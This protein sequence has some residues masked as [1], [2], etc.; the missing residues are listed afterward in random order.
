MFLAALNTLFIK[1]AIIACTF[2]LWLPFLK[3]LYV[4]LND[5]L[6]AE[7]GLFGRTPTQRELRLITRDPTRSKSPL[8]SEEFD[9]D[10]PGQRRAQPTSTASGQ[11][12]ATPK[13]ARGPAPTAANFGFSKPR[14]KRG[15]ARKEQR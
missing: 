9:P 10:R 3:A 6:A 14:G 8:V 12:Q 4:E 1:Y 7:G 13:Q 2:P 5:A 11:R 15:F